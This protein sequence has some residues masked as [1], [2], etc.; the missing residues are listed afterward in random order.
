LN[1]NHL[2]SI[3]TRP[4]STESLHASSAKNDPDGARTLDANRS[5]RAFRATPTQ[6]AASHRITDFVRIPP[7]SMA[8]TLLMSFLSA[9]PSFAI[10]MSLPAITETAAS[11]RVA[12]AQAGLMMSLFMVGFAVAPLFYGPASDRYGRKPIV[13]FACMLFVIAGIGCALAQ[14]LPTLLMWRVVQGAGAGASMTIALAII[15]DLFEGQAARTK[16]SYVTIATMIVPMIAPTAGAALLALGGWR[17]IHAVLAGVGLFL[18]LAMLLGFAESARINPANRLV[19]SVIAR[20]YLRVLMHP[21]CLGYILVSSTTF[22]ALFAYVSGSSLFLINV[23]GLRPL[24]YG[25]V[26]AATSLGIMAG[27]FLNTRLSARGVLPFYPLAAGLLLAVVSTILLLAMTLVNWMP[28]PLFIS[29]LVLGNLAFGLTAPNAMQGA[30]Q[31]LPQIAGAAGAATGCIQ[32]TTAAVVSGLVAELYDGH[33]A[34]SMTAF[35]A[36]C[37]LLAL[38]A[39]LLLARPA[40]CVVVLP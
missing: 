23:V 1:A 21:L 15:R 32:M 34:L 14:S 4:Q 33:S 22:G 31:P 29:L 3:A 16:L 18:L 2:A 17:V 12:P 35:M 7:A 30:M 19:P 13:V 28:L 8:F 39:Y 9:L 40:E 37:S 25:L 38:I 24:Q 27:A 36:L 10:D 5:F 11:L 6:S 20:N 26:F